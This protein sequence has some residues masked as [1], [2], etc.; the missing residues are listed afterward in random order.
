MA[1]EVLEDFEKN[2][3]KFFFCSRQRLEWLLPISNIGSR[4]S[5]EVVTGRHQVRR[6]GAAARAVAHTRAS[7]RAHDLGNARATWARQ[8]K[9]AT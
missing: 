5:F 8:G 3:N 1:E 6:A 7:A 2:K 4:P 9:V